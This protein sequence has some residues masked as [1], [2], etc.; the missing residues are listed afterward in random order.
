VT[1]DFLPESLIC[2][3]LTAQNVQIWLSFNTGQRGW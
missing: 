2:A 3:P 1:D